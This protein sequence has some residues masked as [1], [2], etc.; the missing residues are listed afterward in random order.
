MAHEQAKVFKL[1]KELTNNNRHISNQK[2]KAKE[3]KDAVKAYEERNDAIMDELGV[4]TE[5]DNL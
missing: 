5:D 4:H 2:L 1:V 3:I